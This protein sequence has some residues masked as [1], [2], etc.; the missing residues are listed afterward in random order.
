MANRPTQKDFRGTYFDGWRQMFETKNMEMKMK[1]SLLLWITLFA[2]AG[3]ILTACS[4]GDTAS[5]AGEWKL[6]SYGDTLN[7][8]PVVPNVDTSINFDSNGKFLGNVGCNSFG[9]DYKVSGD[10]I[11]F[12]SIAST[13]MF[14]EETSSQESAILSILS[15][16]VVKYQING[17][18]LKITS[19]DGAFVV[20]L[21]RK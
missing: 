14:C 20:V 18:L 11:T 6:V 16:R 7:P 15:D 1:K 5:L 2:F 3:L 12:G 8:T 13:L 9:S 21:A 17:E 10:Q 19:A 4:S